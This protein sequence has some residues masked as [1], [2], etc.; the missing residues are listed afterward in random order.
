MLHAYCYS[1]T[2]IEKDFRTRIQYATPYGDRLLLLG[3]VSFAQSQD[4]V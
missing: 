1:I 2:K 3:H 4:G